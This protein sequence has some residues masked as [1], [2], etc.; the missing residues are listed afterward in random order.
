MNDVWI[1]GVVTGIE[2]LRFTPAGFPVIKFKLFHESVQIEN[3]VE[4]S[5]AVMLDVSAV[6]DVTKSI[7]SDIT[8]GKIRVRG[9]LALSNRRSKQPTLHAQALTWI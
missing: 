3:G 9:F 2:P 7:S 5:I 6:G 4:R 1:E 8:Q